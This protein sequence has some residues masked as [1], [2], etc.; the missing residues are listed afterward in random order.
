ML[1][2][3]A[4][5]I[6]LALLP[7]F[8]WAVDLQPNDIVAPLPDKNYV[9]LSYSTSEKSR[10]YKNG[11]VY[12]AAP[13]SNPIVTTESEFIRISRSYMVGG[14]P[15]IS[16]IQIPYGTIKPSGSLSAYASDTGMGDTTLATAIWPYADRDSRTYF[17]LAAYLSTPTGSYF[18]QQ[19]FNM[20]ENR[21][22][23]ALQMGFQKPIYGDLEGSIAFDTLWFGNN[24]QCAAVCASASNL[25][26]SQ[27]PLY[28][29]Q[30]GLIY[31]VNP[32]LTV[33]ATYFYVTGGATAYN[34]VD[35]PDTFNITQRYLLSALIHTNIGRF[36]VQYGRDFDVKNGFM[37]TS[38]L[39]IRYVRNFGH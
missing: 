32:V 21:Y 8:S 9:T 14:M 17:G 5:L 34:N 6:A 36:S 37:Q 24:H 39:S 27:K 30:L 25:S 11:V 13:Y 19:A 16:Y 15:G 12:S 10:Y 18:A 26:L 4:I 3:S 33:G 20:G 38:A 2:F 35:R 31:K 29:T 23:S 7:L 1:R 28:T 22:K